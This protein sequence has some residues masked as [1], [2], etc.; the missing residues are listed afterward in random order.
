V[1]TIED[2][3]QLQSKSN[4]LLVKLEE[5][6]SNEWQKK[7]D[8]IEEFIIVNRTL[9]E[10]GKIQVVKKEFA[11]YIVSKL[12][13]RNITVNR[14][15]N[16]YK[17]FNSDEIEINKSRIES[18]DQKATEISSG[19]TT[20]EIFRD[21][22]LAKPKKETAY[23]K[24]LEK[25]MKTLDDAKSLNNAL[26][27]KYNEDDEYERIM[28]DNFNEDM[29]LEL[30]EAHSV[31]N[32][33]RKQIDDRNKLSNYQKL[34]LQLL[35]NLGQTKAKAAQDVGYCSKYLSIG[36]ERNDELTKLWDWV[37]ECHVCH[38]DIKAVRDKA[39]QDYE[40]GNEIDFDVPIKGY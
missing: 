1:P 10:N 39:I 7:K 14:N 9:L 2:F 29:V 16:F 26:L 33:A 4:Q 36:I 3:E 20:D 6:D 15:G 38:S 24:Y 11:S 30:I 27:E 35:V 19:R 12:N 5:L 40:S 17:M 22:V 37:G 18:V 32:L 34:N 8:L 25:E 21:K 23:T 28:D 31:I 13:E